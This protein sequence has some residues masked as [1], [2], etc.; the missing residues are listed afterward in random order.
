MTNII[1]IRGAQPVGKADRSRMET[2]LLTQDIVRSWRTPPFQRPLRVNPK[3]VAISQ[4]MKSNG[5][6]ITGV[7]T[8]G[9]LGPDKIYYIVD[10]QHRIEAA[11]ISELEEFIADVRLVTF[12]TMAEMAQEF[13]KLNTALVRFNPD[14]ILR[15]LE[16]SSKALTHIR[17]NCAFVGYDNIRRKPGSPMVSMASAL[18]CWVGSHGDTPTGVSTGAATLAQQLTLEDAEELTRFLNIAFHA[19]GRDL[20]YARLWGNLNLTSCMWLYRK[21]VV[22]R[23]R[24]VKRFLLLSADA[25]RKCLMAVSAKADYIDWLVNRNMSERD[26]SPCYGRLREIFTKRL[27]DGGVKSPKLPSPAWSTSKSGGRSR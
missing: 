19:W 12:D 15:G 23:Q 17:T 20:E 13:V 21:L 4:E 14:D 16:G 18:R 22:E 1:P 2:L 11:K 24:G 26:R 27:I 5:G 25:F 3:V 9:V 10:G 8:L 6:F 7:L